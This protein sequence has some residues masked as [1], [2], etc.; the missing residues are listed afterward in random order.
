MTTPYQGLTRTSHMTTGQ[1][2]CTSNWGEVADTRAVNPLF[3]DDNTHNHISVQGSH[4]S[5]RS[6]SDSM[7]ITQDGEG[8]HRQFLEE[9]TPQL[10]TQLRV[11]Y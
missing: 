6:L 2:S 1:D 9:V 10:N 3:G 4:M 8:A 5:I 11:T 7:D